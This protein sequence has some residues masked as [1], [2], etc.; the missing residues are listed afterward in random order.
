M[1]LLA[2]LYF[3]GALAVGLPILFHLIRRRPK[4]EV[5]FSS[6]M[7]LK[8][9]PPR[10]TR[11]SRLENLPLLLIRS[12]ALILLAAAFAR[13]FLRQTAQSDVDGLSRRLVVAI[14]TS[15]SMRR[16]DLWQQAKLAAKTVIDD[17]QPGDQLAIVAFD[18]QPQ[19][20]FGFDQ[21]AQLTPSQLKSA[22]NEAIDQAAPTW[23]TSDLGRA[24]GFAA[25]LAVTHEQDDNVEDAVDTDTASVQSGPAHLVLVSDMQVGSEIESL[26]VYAWPDELTLDVR[27]VGTDKT[28]NAWATI[29]SGDDS[30]SVD[31]GRQNRVRVRVSNTADAENATFRIA[32]KDALGRILSESEMPVQVPPGESR[33]VSLPAPAS[34][35]SALCVLDD[36]HA[37]DNNTYVANREPV[38]QKLLYVGNDTL[39]TSNVDPKDSLYYYLRRVPLSNRY[40]HVDVEAVPDGLP[41]EL[42]PHE[43]PLIVVAG[44]VSS[45]DATS[46]RRYIE[47]GGRLLV[48]F[49][50]EQQTSALLDLVREMT[51]EDTLSADEANIDDYVMLSQIQFTDP[52]FMSMADPQFNDFTKIRFWKH[53]KLTGV[54]DHWKVTAAFDDGDPALIEVPTQAADSDGKLWILATGWQPTSSQLALSTKFIPLVYQWFDSSSADSQRSE[55]YAVGEPIDAP[56]SESARIIGPDGTAFRYQSGED[57]G[58]IDQPGVYQFDDG[59]HIHAFAVNVAESESN[60]E[61][62]DDDSLERFGV[63][64]G[65][66]PTSQQ[67]R[68]S[69]RQ[70]RDVELEGRQKLWQWLL[71]FGLTM[72][73]IES[74]LGGRMS[75][76]TPAATA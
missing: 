42:P 21:S 34:D 9:T 18:D 19:M 10:L 51:S 46:L 15:A 58:N 73:F 11:R 35:V 39:A 40:R 63:K 65:A 26:Q 12:L 66:A 5:E 67:L 52:V 29:L 76:S 28:T 30:S 55:S 72:L 43:V 56:P 71:V 14:D 48:V 57:L 64:L 74:W 17:I 7:F 20:L 37:F 3:L 62:A 59:Q 36:D 69:G 1:S 53:R 61:A 70:L 45:Q 6:L 49:G 13:P 33:V 31:Q 16:A 27:R 60:T 68:D 22:A 2:P 24:L 50:S 25:D 75:R 4:G 32:W 44:E 23:K 41:S 54:P 47:R 8:P 38:A